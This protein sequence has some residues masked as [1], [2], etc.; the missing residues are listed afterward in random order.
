MKWVNQ[1]PI[2][3]VT[4]FQAP[5]KTKIRTLHVSCGNA[6]GASFYVKY[7]TKGGTAQFFLTP[8]LFTPPQLSTWDCPGLP[9]TMEPGDSLVASASDAANYDLFLD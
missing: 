1:I 7:L 8:K 3:P 9:F 4:I 6:A 5:T 2:A